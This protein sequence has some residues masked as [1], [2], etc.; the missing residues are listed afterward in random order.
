MIQVIIILS[1][2]IK[3]HQF[4]M[5]YKRDDQEGYFCKADNLICLDIC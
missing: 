4:R 5:Q 3:I 2:M 1:K